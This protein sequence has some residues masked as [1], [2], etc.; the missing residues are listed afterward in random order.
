MDKM[1]RMDYEKLCNLSA[2]M[3]GVEASITTLWAVF[4]EDCSLSNDVIRDALFAIQE[5]IERIRVDIMEYAQ[6]HG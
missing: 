1:D 5:H 6:A 2:E 3:N 4:E